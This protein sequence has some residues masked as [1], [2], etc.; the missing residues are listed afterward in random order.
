[1]VSL[2]VG[3][4]PTVGHTESCLLLLGHGKTAAVVQGWAGHGGIVAILV[5]EVPAPP[6]PARGRGSHVAGPPT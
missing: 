6:R 2:A 3:V 5:G 1:M 4:L